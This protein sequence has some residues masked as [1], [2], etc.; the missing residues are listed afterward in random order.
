MALIRSRQACL[1]SFL[2]LLGSQGAAQ[3]LPDPTT[4]ILTRIDGQVTLSAESRAEFRPVRLAAQRQILRR[5][6]TLH[7]PPGAQVTLVCSTE[8]LVS[9]TGPLDWA[10]DARTCAQ[11]LRLPENSYRNLGAY[12]GRI[13]PRNGTLLLELEARNV[14][15]GLGPILLSPRNTT[16]MDA[17]PRLVW[18]Q[19]QDAVEYEI[20]IRDPARIVIRLPAKDLHCG[21]GSGPWRDLEVCSWEPSSKWPALEPDSPVSLMIGS[22]KILAAPLPQDRD[23]YQVH[24]LSV[25]DQRGLQDR[26]HQIAALPLDKTSRLLLTVGSYIKSELYSDAIAAYHEALQEQEMPRARVTLGDLYLK[27]GLPVL[28]DVEYRQALAGVSDS[29]LEAAA[30]L[31][32]G[33]VAY[34]LKNFSEARAH[35]E[36]ASALYLALGLPAEAAD[37]EEAAGRSQPA[38]P[39]ARKEYERGRP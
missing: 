30:E 34:S 38:N 10:L 9:L 2:F 31:G 39:P 11:G 14:D 24:L 5:G 22:R 25:D 13:L 17:S 28:A 37:A 32:R 35:F 26:L 23:V 15:M 19:V 12:A 4:A 21:R 36:L 20:E 3:K 33:Y 7:V 18:T 29:S 1:G 8:T 27:I 6:D 16:V